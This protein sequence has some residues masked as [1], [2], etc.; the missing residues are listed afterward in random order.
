[1]STT[2]CISIYLQLFILCTTATLYTVGQ[3]CKKKIVQK[4]VLDS[5]IMT[6]FIIKLKNTTR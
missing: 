1:M 3:K 2:T 6:L 4:I 5:K